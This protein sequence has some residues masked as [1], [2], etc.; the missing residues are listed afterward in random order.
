MRNPF[1]LV[2]VAG[3]GV[4]GFAVWLLKG[5]MNENAA[6]LAAARAA[7]GENVPLVEVYAAAAPLRYGESLDEDKVGT[8]LWPAHAVPEGAFVEGGDVVLMAE[9]GVRL[10]TRAVDK[11]EIILASKV[12]KPGGEVGITSMLEPGMRA[13]SIN[14]NAQTGVSG[15]LRPGDMVDVF[16]TGDL[17]GREVTR[18]VQPS[19]QIIAVDQSS[20]MDV[21]RTSVADTVSV[22]TTPEQAAGL[23]HAQAEGRL[24]L[25][26]VGVNDDAGDAELVQVDRNKLFGIQEVVA[27]AP[28]PEPERCYINTRRGGE[29]VRVEIACTN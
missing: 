17:E 19:V 25:S 15:L 5:Y 10:M 18:L 1:I 2:L 14:V 7:V 27:E 24:T 21:A 26:L 20:D 6:A 28:A 22:M 16:W 8:I 11:G 4:A 9:G 12:T 3:I 13:I 29:L 23:M